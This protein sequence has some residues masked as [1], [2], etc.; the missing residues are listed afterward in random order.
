M[1]KTINI[2]SIFL[3][4]FLIFSCS[5]TKKDNNNNSNNKQNNEDTQIQDVTFYLIPSATDILSVLDYENLKFSEDIL[6]PFDS[7]ERFETKKSQEIALGL[8]MADM[9]YTTFC[10]KSNQV[11]NTMK[12]IK[13][14]TNKTDIFFNFGLFHEGAANKQKG[15]ETIINFYRSIISDIEKQNRP[16]TLARVSTSA[17]IQSLFIIVNLA[18]EYS[19]DNPTIQLIADQKYVIDNLFLYL[20]KVNGDKQYL[21]E[22]INDLKPV[23]E[24]YDNLTIIKIEEQV[25]ET[26]P[27]GYYLVGGTTKILITKEQFELLKK[28]ITEIRNKLALINV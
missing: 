13:I 11:I 18:G 14:T 12:G 23:K 2:I 15:V 26:A 20:E 16:A 6:T 24:I 4:S 9:T 5:E 7:T 17:W 22:I 8:Y 10:N 3:L 1:K 19:D 28:T 27:E 25:S 21:T